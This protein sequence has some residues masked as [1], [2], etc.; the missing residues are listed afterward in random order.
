MAVATPPQT[1]IQ[2]AMKAR[3]LTYAD[4]RALPD[5]GTRYELVE[6]KLRE[7]PSPTVSHQ[8]AL[9]QLLKKMDEFASEKKLGEVLCAPLDVQLS[10]DLCYQPDVLFVAKESKAKITD[11]DVQGAPDLVVEIVSPSSRYT[12]RKEKMGN[13]A[14]YGVRE[15]WLVYPETIFVE[16][17]VLR[18]GKYEMLGRYGEGETMR[19]EILAGLEFL[20]ETMFE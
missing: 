10:D 14:N 7:M 6:G 20:T 5:D 19:S 12:D 4:Y 16:V 13:Y 3:R 15:Y 8:R 9:K 18:E 11:V 2:P 17:F 1:N